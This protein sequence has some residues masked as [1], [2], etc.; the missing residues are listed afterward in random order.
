MINFKGKGFY[1]G[2]EKKQ[3]FFGN[4]PCSMEQSL[5][6]EL[7]R[8]LLPEEK[9]RVLQFAALD[10]MPSSKLR[11]HA[12]RLLEL[13]FEYSWQDPAQSLEKRAVFDRLFPGQDFV[14]G[15]LEKIMV[16]ALKMV[17]STLLV[18][19]YFRED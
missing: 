17:R 10:F 8:T 11:A 18:K 16:E 9:A 3:H 1:F 15:K 4:I 19:H 14:D 2:P 7:I 6:I 12:I 13:C 5:L